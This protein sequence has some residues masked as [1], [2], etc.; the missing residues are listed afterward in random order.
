MAVNLSPV[1]GV[2]AQF[3]TNTGAVLTG[4][5]IYTYAAGTTTPAATYTSSGGNTPWSNP[6]VLDAAGRVPSGGE[7]WL[8][9]GIS[10]KFVLKDSTDVLIATYDNITGI[11]SNSVSFTNQQQII[12]A[13]ANQTVFNLSIS[14]QPG[15]NSLS[16][17]VDGVNQ[18]GPGAQYAYTETDSDTVTFVSGLHVGAVVKFTTTQQQGA[19]VTNASQITYTPFG[20][21]A[22]TTNVQAKLRQV[23]S[24]LDFIPVGTSTD[25]VDCSTWINNAINSG[26]QCIYFPQGIYAISAPI[27][28]KPFTQLWGVDGGN[29]SNASSSRIVALAPFVGDSMIQSTATLVSGEK[30]YGLRDLFVNANLIVK[31]CIAWDN[32][33]SGQIFN[34]TASNAKEYG[35]KITNSGVLFSANVTMTNCYVRMPNDQY[36]INPAGFP[37]YAAYYLDGLFHVMTNCLSDGGITGIEFGANALT[38]NNIVQNCHPEGFLSVGIAVNDSIG[39]NQIIANQI[40]SIYSAS[41]NPTPTDIQIGILINGAGDGNIIAENQITCLKYGATLQTN[42]FGILAQSVSPDPNA[43]HTITGNQILNFNYGIQISSPFTSCSNNNLNAKISG[44]IVN[45]SGA[46]ISG[47]YINYDTGT[48]YAVRVNSGTGTKVSQITT[49]TAPIK[50]YNTTLLDAPPTVMAYRNSGQTIPNSTATTVIFD[51]VEYDDYS[52][53]STTTGIYTVPF[54]GTGYYQVTAGVQLT[55]STTSFALAIQ[56]QGVEKRKNINTDATLTMTCVTGLVYLQEGWSL[57]I[58][59]T[60][61]GPKTTSSGISSC[62]FNAVKVSRPLS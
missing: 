47:G 39:Q 35:F 51:T 27:Q 59:A 44:Y 20:A 57:Q 5:K 10:Y 23:V 2:A 48:G 3:F 61:A 30:R 4:G 50:L 41:S 16:V 62:Y 56:V 52:G 37:V 54:G 8:T 38:G 12:T 53:Y 49:A 11:N 58:V 19:G 24:V 55:A 22:V 42:S 36:L 7:I 32:V 34:V 26:A 25:L 1:G 31:N 21:N 28:L 45:A 15:T 40:I 14:Y 18:Y 13:T 43:G 29:T 17:F 6:I 9:D 60:L 33:N 46:S